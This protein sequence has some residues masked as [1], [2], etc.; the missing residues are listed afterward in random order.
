MS[1]LYRYILGSVMYAYLVQVMLLMCPSP[2]GVPIDETLVYIH[3]A[4]L[5]VYC[6]LAGLGIIFA[7]VCLGINIYFREKKYVLL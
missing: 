3:V 6:I 1:S 2:D 7:F 4:L 5:V